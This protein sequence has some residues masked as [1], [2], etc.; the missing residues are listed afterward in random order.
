MPKTLLSLLI[1]LPL[2][3]IVEQG[4]THLG[5]AALK[6]PMP[7]NENREKDPL[8]QLT[9]EMKGLQLVRV[10]KAITRERKSGIIEAIFNA[11]KLMAGEKPIILC[12]S[13]CDG[14]EALTSIYQTKGGVE[15]LNA[16]DF[17][18]GSKERECLLKLEARGKI[19][20]VTNF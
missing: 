9:F 4:G 12:W 17:N 16:A 14:V 15:I 20:G 6:E 10:C 19:V 2:T 8:E 18:F 3:F 5:M 13:K 1:S 11:A 7:K